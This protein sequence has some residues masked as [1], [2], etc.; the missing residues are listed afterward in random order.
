MALQRF[1]NR[2]RLLKRM[3]DEVIPI[4]IILVI[5]TVLAYIAIRL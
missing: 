2:K 3:R 5:L 4:A 1:M